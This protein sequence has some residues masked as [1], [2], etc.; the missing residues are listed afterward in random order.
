[1]HLSEFCR[2]MQYSGYR[3]HFREEIIR[4]ALTAFQRM[5]ERE[6]RGETPIHRERQWKRK[7]RKREKRQKKENWYKK[8]GSKTLIFIPATPKSELKKRYEK[9]IDES[10]IK[11][12]VI[13]KR[14]KTLQNLLQKSKPTTRRRC[15]EDEGCM[16]CEND[17][18]SDC[19][20]ENVTYEILCE[21]CKK[22]YIGETSKNAYTRGQQHKRLLQTKD[23]Q[24]V[25]YRHIQQDHQD[26]TTT[27]KMKVLQTHRSALCRQITEAVK[28]SR[29]PRDKLINN[30]TE[31]GHNKIVRTQMVYE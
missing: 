22:V 5:R 8:D 7:E 15:G 10:K 31:W 12:K 28:I 9:V 29:T 24:S 30:K 13:E 18:K 26:E 2:R 17:G 14:G 27:F 20:K 19:R 1:M 11:I 4:S 21:K 23:K 3:E 25:L 6:E 16:I